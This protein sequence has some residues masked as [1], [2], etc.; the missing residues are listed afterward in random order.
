MERIIPLGGGLRFAPPNTGVSALCAH[1]PPQSRA[2]CQRERGVDRERVRRLRQKSVP[3]GPKWPK[4][5]KFGPGIATFV[6][7]CYLR[8]QSGAM[9]SWSFRSVWEAVG[10]Q[11][12]IRTAYKTWRQ[13]R[14]NAWLSYITEVLQL[15][16]EHLRVA[17]P[18]YVTEEAAQIVD[19]DGAFPY[20]A[21]STH[22]VVAFFVRWCASDP[23]RGVWTIARTSVP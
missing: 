15:L 7:G 20:A 16:A 8:H 22:V 10:T 17:L 21:A 23:H 13:Y 6:I 2:S 1:A 4:L 9:R 11:T 14:W 19:D 12:L 18:K 5:A 3:N